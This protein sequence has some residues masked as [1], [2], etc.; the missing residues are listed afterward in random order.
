MA[1][2]DFPSA[3]TLNQT[4]TANGKTYIWNGVSWVNNS[5]GFTGSQGSVGYT[6]SQGPVGYT[7]SLGSQGPSGFT[8]ST[9]PT[10]S[11]G[12]TGS[13][14]ATG[15][16]GP[17]GP[18]G[19]TGSWG[20]TAGAN[21]DMNSYSIN[22]VNQLNATGPITAGYSN[23]NQYIILGDDG[24]IEIVRAAG[25]A[26]IDFK[27]LGAEDF[28]ARISQSGSG[29][30]ITGAVY[31]PQFYDSENTVYSANPAG[32]SY[33]NSAYFSDNGTVSSYVQVGTNYIYGTDSSS[34]WYLS[35]GTDNNYV[36]MSTK[37]FG[38]GVSSPSQKLH[39]SGIG[40]ATID[41]R[42]PLFYDSDNTA[43]YID[44]NNTS[45]INALTCGSFASSDAAPTW[46]NSNFQYQE[47]LSDHLAFYKKTGSY[48]IYWRRS[49][50]G[51]AG[52]ANNFEMMSLNDS[53]TLA[54]AA[55]M[56]APIFYDTNNTSYYIDPNS[57]SVIADIYNYGWYRSYGLTGWYNQTYGGGIYMSGT[58][59]VETYGSKHFACDQSIRTP[60]YYDS[61]DTGYFVN[62]NGSSNLY[63]DLSIYAGELNFT[64]AGQKY[65]DF[66]GNMIFR[67]SDNSTFFT[68]RML[69]GTG[70][71]V[72]S[73]GD[74]RAPI[75]YDSNDT[76]YYTDPA[77]N[78]RLRNINLGGGSG[79]DATIHIVGIQGG[80]GRLTQMSPNGASQAGLNIMSARNGSNSDLW[81][82]WGVN[83][84]NYWYINSG[85]GF[86][87][88][89]GMIIDSGGN[90]TCAGNI[91]AYSDIRFKENIESVTNA[92]AK[93]LSLR[94]V[95][96]TLK[97]DDSKRRKLGVIAQEVEAVVPEVVMKFEEESGDEILSVD[98]GN[99]VGLLIE[100]IKEQQNQINNLQ[101][102]INILRG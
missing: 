62:P 34:D 87:T 74:F 18:I 54:V 95:T 65:I 26:Y 79:F 50:D 8:G 16:T 14:G 25:A 1:V 97:A 88:G 40:Y 17:T 80:N 100:S 4:Y 78:T 6:G 13:Q 49:D 15:S 77:V 76:G 32:T 20:G 70:G 63:G 96:Y 64:G 89:T 41:W 81:W 57:A 93:T 23:T 44:G 5:S 19:Y 39:V 60:I 30:A 99:M 27:N 69:I 31:S 11:I 9:G 22:H 21:V 42:A 51:Y 75:F 48:K 45:N 85:V 94:G 38:I 90:M 82:T 72:E 92:L 91:T 3:P 24:N 7:G 37:K 52:G 58:T 73:Y 33:F 101:E 35:A 98:Y 86:N 56:R 84:N 83:T 29:L 10:G 53:G 102:Q 68:N 36:A 43:Y 55:D 66:N 46:T 12:F 67:Y 59:F 71:N 28:D 2:L 61:N 47:H